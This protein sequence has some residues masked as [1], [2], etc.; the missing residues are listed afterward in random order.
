MCQNHKPSKGLFGYYGTPEEIIFFLF[1]FFSLKERLQK[2]VGSKDRDRFKKDK[3]TRMFPFLGRGEDKVT[4]NHKECDWLSL[5]QKQSVPDSPLFGK[6]C[7]CRIFLLTHYFTM[8]SLLYTL[9]TRIMRQ[10]DSSFI[11]DIVRSVEKWCKLA[12]NILGNNVARKKNI[13][14]DCPDCGFS[15]CKTSLFAISNQ[16]VSQECF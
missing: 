12:N 7:F 16:L 6:I 2:E 8:N 15:F 4:F 14:E 13:G 1:F 10:K 3:S 11:S 9:Q 5:Q